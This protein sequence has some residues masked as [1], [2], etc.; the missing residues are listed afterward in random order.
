MTDV[1]TDVRQ[2]LLRE[3]LDAALIARA[4]ARVRRRWGGSQTYV[5]AH[6]RAERDDHI[7]AA[8]EAGHPI[9]A[10]AAQAGCSPATVRRRKSEWL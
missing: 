3:G 7:R 6:D 1:L 4:I 10:A 8:L 2:E 9:D 5:R